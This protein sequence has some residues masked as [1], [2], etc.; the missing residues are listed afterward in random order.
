MARRRDY[1]EPRQ[2]A[3][4]GYSLTR[5]AF[6]VS[7]VLAWTVV[8]AVVVGA[9]RESAQAVAVAGIVVPSM[10]VMIAALLGI[11]RAF[12]S[13]D[14]RSQALAADKPPEGE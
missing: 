9:L 12:G 11:H 1:S 3:R 13:V 10:V 6:W 14:L 8:L 7:F 2:I 5:L 4:P